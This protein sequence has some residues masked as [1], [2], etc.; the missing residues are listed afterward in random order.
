MATAKKKQ[1]FQNKPEPK[2]GFNEIPFREA[3]SLYGEKDWIIIPVHGGV[4][5]RPRDLNHQIYRATINKLSQ[6]QKQNNGD[7]KM[8]RVSKL[9]VAKTEDKEKKAKK[10]K[11]VDVSEAIPEV[12]EKKAKKKKS[13]ESETKETFKDRVKRLKSEK[14]ED[15]VKPKK[16]KVD[17]EVVSP[18][19]AKGKKLSTEEI[20]E[21]IIFNEAGKV[22]PYSKVISDIINHDKLKMSLEEISEA[23]DEHYTEKL[24]VVGV[25]AM[26]RIIRNNN[27]SGKD[28]IARPTR[29][30]NRIVDTYEQ[31]K[32]SSKGRGRPPK[33]G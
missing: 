13:V 1:K 27:E 24:K 15:S 8:A 23:I 29:K 28:Y 33:N 9:S 10:K 2:I 6:K 3:V 19:P 21:E 4:S 32:N 26:E 5:C 12:S 31:L 14:G 17:A 22:R 16:E 11:V 30:G 18:K 7:E 25:E 20:I